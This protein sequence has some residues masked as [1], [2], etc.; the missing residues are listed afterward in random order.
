VRVDYDKNADFGSYKTFSFL[1]W[2]D[3]SD[4]LLNDLDKQ[5]IHDAFKNE[6]NKRG[7]TY[8]EDGDIAILLHI[9]VEEKTSTTAYTTHM[10]GYGGYRYGRW[11]WGGGV[12]TTNYTE[13]DYL[14]GTL[15]FDVFDKE[16]QSLV[17]EAVASS[18]IKENPKGREKRINKTAA[19]MLKKFPINPVE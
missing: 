2:Q 3:N 19:K 14:F 4:Q 10:G 1:G 8:A 13:N 15:V 12:S 16:T 6:L 7:L 18:A 9:V 17:W 5:R 11:G